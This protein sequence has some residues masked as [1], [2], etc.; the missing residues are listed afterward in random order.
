MV[1]A[2]QVED[3]SMWLVVP[4]GADRLTCYSTT[5]QRVASIL[6]LEVRVEL[7]PSAD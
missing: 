3:P 2:D 7:R 6:G 1:R 5:L 4:L